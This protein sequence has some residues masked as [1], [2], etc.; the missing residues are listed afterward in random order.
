MIKGD[1]IYCTGT[2]NGTGITYRFGEGEA[3][4][5]AFYNGAGGGQHDP[6]GFW[7]WRLPEND[8]VTTM[9]NVL[10]SGKK[11]ALISEKDCK[12]ELMNY[13]TRIQT[14][15]NSMTLQNLMA[16]EEASAV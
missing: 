10:M 13:R 14:K 2:G 11:T 1:T 3:A 6:L 8:T 16:P 4:Y 7:H 12:V 9:N 15:T 5:L